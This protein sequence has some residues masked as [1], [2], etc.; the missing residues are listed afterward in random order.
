MQMTLKMFTKGIAETFVQCKFSKLNR[1]FIFKSTLHLTQCGDCLF[2]QQIEMIK[3]ILGHIR[4]GGL[5]WGDKKICILLR[6]FSKF[7][8]LNKQG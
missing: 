3:I 2:Q 7:L 1:I 8:K 4:E 5:K 6:C